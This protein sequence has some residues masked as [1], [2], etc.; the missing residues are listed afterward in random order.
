MPENEDICLS[1]ELFSW[2]SDFLSFGVLEF[3]SG[4][5][6]KKPGL[7]RVGIID[8]SEMNRAVVKVNQQHVAII[9]KILLLK[10]S[11]KAN[12][13]VSLVC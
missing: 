2:V 3:F 1:F 10:L 8:K 9:L 11:E 5:H 13:Y 6:K 12:E 4:V 7:K